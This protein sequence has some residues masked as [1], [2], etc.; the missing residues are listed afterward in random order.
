VA[1]REIGVL[2]TVVIGVAGMPWLY[3]RSLV[4]MRWNWKRRRSAVSDLYGLPRAPMAGNQSSTSC[5]ESRRSAG[6]ATAG[7]NAEEAETGSREGG[8]RS[9]SLCALFGGKLWDWVRGWVGVLVTI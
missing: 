1:E 8:A 9:R 7:S 2:D 5:P 6:T 3:A 4:P